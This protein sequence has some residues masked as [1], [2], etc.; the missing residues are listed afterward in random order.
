MKK[1]GKHTSLS[2]REF[3]FDLH[4][5]RQVIKIQIHEVRI[6]AYDRKSFYALNKKET[7]ADQIT[8]PFIDGEIVTI[9]RI[10]T[11]DGSVSFI[12]VRQ[13]AEGVVTTS[14]PDADMNDE[15]FIQIRKSLVEMA[16]KEDNAD[17]KY[18]RKFISFEN[19][20]EEAGS[21]ESVEDEYLEALDN[22]ERL[23][24]EE[25]DIT[26]RTLKNAT[27]ILDLLLSDKQKRWFLMSTRDDLSDREIARREGVNQSTVSRGL[28]VIEKK[29]N[30]FLKNFS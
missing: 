28:R 17:S 2:T 24:I 25:T 18:T 29:I 10:R 8:Y 20:S 14:V 13:N 5:N 27:K 22:Q 12:Q 11:E 19:L 4:A 1:C 9:K 21:R 15:L 23:R 7:D 16:R 3:D 26:A 6:M 30:K